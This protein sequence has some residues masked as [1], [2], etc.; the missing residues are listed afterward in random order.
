MAKLMKCRTCDKE[1]AKSAKVCPHCG[2][3]KPTKKKTN[4]KMVLLGIIFIGV[5]MALFG[6]TQEEMKAQ[7]KAERK[8]K[9]EQ[10]KEKIAQLLAEVKKIPSDNYEENYFGYKKLVDLEPSNKN[11]VKK[12]A[13]YKAGYDLMENIC[14]TCR[15]EA[16]KRNKASLNNPQ[17][18]KTVTYLDKWDKGTYYYQEEFI[19]K[20]AFGVEFKLVSK[21]K[22]T[23]NKDKTINITKIF[24][25]KA[26]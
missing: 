2:E 4:I 21:F 23:I 6:P 1:I 8:I 24:L 13:H 19:G 3:K 7:Q 11:Y 20:N 5:L 12:L 18:Y 9:I 16:R 17:T 10:K 14:S 22:C 15:I 26:M 25:R